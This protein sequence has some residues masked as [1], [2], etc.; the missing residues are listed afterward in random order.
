MLTS[1][2]FEMFS[3]LRV[4]TTKSC[5]IGCLKPTLTFSSE[6]YMYMNVK[7]K[8]TVDHVQYK[9]GFKVE[10]EKSQ[11]LR[12]KETDS[13]NLKHTRTICIVHLTC[14]S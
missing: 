5:S 6:I 2:T 12:T 10:T 14:I 7:Q 1:A 13:E 11:M 8:K 9:Q 3:L 4:F